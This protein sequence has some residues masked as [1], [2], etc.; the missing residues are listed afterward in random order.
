MSIAIGRNSSR[1][2]SG[3]NEGAPTLVAAVLEM[4]FGIVLR[5]RGELEVEFLLL[6]G[7]EQRANLVVP[8]V[9]R[10]SS[11][12]GPARHKPSA[13][14]WRQFQRPGSIERKEDAGLGRT[15]SVKAFSSL[16]PNWTKM[17]STTCLIGCCWPV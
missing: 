14:R 10:A 17:L 11:P 16:D 3:C 8:F 9:L 15:G 1:I 6:L 13:R 4:P 2:N 7:R 12:L 5:R